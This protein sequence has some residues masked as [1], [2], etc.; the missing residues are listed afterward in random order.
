M[1][2]KHFKA[3]RFTLSTSRSRQK[4]VMSS[5]AQWI[6]C[7]IFLVQC[8]KCQNLIYDLNLVR[9]VLG[10]ILQYQNTVSCKL[11][12]KTVLTNKFTVPLRYR[13]TQHVAGFPPENLLSPVVGWKGGPLAAKH[14]FCFVTGAWHRPAADWWQCPTGN[15]FM[16]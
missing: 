4:N 6:C 1:S 2:V 12:R 7:T 5:T 13:S 9:L 16:T 14:V 11:S 3:G 15:R 10:Y 8:S